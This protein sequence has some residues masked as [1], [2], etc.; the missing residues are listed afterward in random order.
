MNTKYS[1]KHFRYNSYLR[2]IQKLVWLSCAYGKFILSANKEISVVQAL[3]TASYFSH[4]IVNHPPQARTLPSPDLRRACPPRVWLIGPGAWQFEAAPASGLKG[5]SSETANVSEFR[6]V[7]PLMRRKSEADRE[8]LFLVRQH[9]LLGFFY[10]TLRALLYTKPIDK[11]VGRTIWLWSISQFNPACAEGATN[12]P[13]KSWAQMG[14]YDS[15][16]GCPTVMPWSCCHG[17]HGI[18]VLKSN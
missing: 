9:F 6:F 3:F 12:I 11:K 10:Y 16:T 13:V 8:M 5:S 4:T 14:S 7:P 18:Q 1:N 2:P 17:G 15:G